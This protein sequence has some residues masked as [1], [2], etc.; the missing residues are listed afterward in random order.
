MNWIELRALNKLY[1]KGETKLNDTLAESGDINYLINSLTIIDK[2]HNKLFAL[3]GF[4]KIYEKDYLEK[5]EQYEKFLSEN[6]L[7]K[8]QTRFDEKDILTLIFIA[9]QKKE[10]IKSVSSIRTFSSEVFKYQGSKYL[11]NK[12]GLKNA[13]CKILGIHDFPDKDPK[14]HQWRLVIDCANPVAIV[15]CENIAHLKNPWK[16]RKANLELWYVGGNNIGVI[17]FIS[18]DKLKLPIYYS[19]DWDFHGLAIYSRIKE[20]FR[21]KSTEINLLMP[22]TGETALPVDSP[23]HQSN[24]VSHETLS[25]LKGDDFSVEEKQLIEKLIRENKWIEEESLNLTSL[26]NYTK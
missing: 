17:D 14:N 19:C 16:A 20:K 18:S 1:T 11:E 21:L 10:L 23:H 2:S 3:K 6:E 4:G 13:V 9:D 12:L 5:Y 7:L 22:Y 8:Q 25:G 24:W 15:L 26:I